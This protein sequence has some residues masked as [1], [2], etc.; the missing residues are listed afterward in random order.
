MEIRNSIFF[1]VCTY[2][3]NLLCTK[4]SLSCIW[5]MAFLFYVN[6]L[7]YSK[8]CF[9]SVYKK[10]HLETISSIQEGR[11]ILQCLQRL[12]PWVMACQGL[13]KWLKP[14]V[15]VITCMRLS[16][17]SIFFFNTGSPP[18]GPFF[19]QA[20][21]IGCLLSKLIPLRYQ[22]GMDTNLTRQGRPRW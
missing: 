2:K 9:S 16:T 15:K 1:Y 3:T 17:I 13:S 12:K 20:T 19:P 21:K 10:N 4:K 5:V 14:W 11:D 18:M 8:R 22:N 6:S 7:R